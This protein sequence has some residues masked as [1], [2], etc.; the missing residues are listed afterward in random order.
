MKKIK[1]GLI[2]D[3]FFGGAGTAYGGYGFLA[4]RLIAKYIPNDLIQIDVLLGRSNKNRY[5]A[6][7]VKVDDVNVYKLPKRKLFSKL[8]LK[9][10]NYDVYLSIE[11]TYDWVLKH[12]LDVNKK[13][14]LWIQDPR[15]AYEWDE[16]NTVK[17]F[18]ETSYY[19]QNIYDLV[20]SM[21][22]QNRVKFISQGYFL[23][24]KAKDLYSLDDDVSIQYL[25]NPVEIDNKFDFDK[26]NKKNNIIFLGRIESVKRGWLFCEIASKLPEYQFYVLGQT[27]RE[28][29]KNTEIINKYLNINNLHFVGHVDGIEKNNFIQD[30]K[31]LVNTSIHEALPISFLEA[32]SYGTVLVSNRNPEDLTSKFGI[33]VGDVL[34]DGFDKVELYVEAIQKLMQNDSIREE[35]AKAGIAYVKNI[36]NIADFTRNLRKIIID[37]VKED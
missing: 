17:L 9:K 18:P 28:S 37:T 6:E 36:H 12:E 13:L 16:I 4:R 20:H 21:Y 26:H 3:E 1:V 35:K 10:Q 23:N 5:F 14:I 25:P 32:L 31:I 22:K 2:I 30:A 15:P 29:D 24:R 27:F 34:G 11:L 8:W 7:K 19:N 33:H